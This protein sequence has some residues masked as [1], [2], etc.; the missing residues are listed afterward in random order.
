[1]TFT[2]RIHRS[3]ALNV[4]AQ[5][6]ARVHET[7]IQIY[8]LQKLAT[9]LAMSSLQLFVACSTVASVQLPEVHSSENSGKFLT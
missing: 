1:M 2:P 3:R 5:F 7:T 4:V 9:S 6:R 8:V